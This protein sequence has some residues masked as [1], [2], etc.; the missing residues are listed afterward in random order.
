MVT[1]ER[2]FAQAYL[3]TEQL[4][5]GATATTISDP[6][7]PSVLGDPVTFVATV[8][9]KTAPGRAVPAGWVEFVVDGEKYGPP[10]KL[11]EHRRATL[12]VRRLEAGRHRVS[13]VYRPAQGSAFLPS[14]SPV[15]VHTVECAPTAGSDTRK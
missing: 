13:A 9:R 3:Q 12:E 10:M 1:G 15:E 6:Q 8:R 5:E 4:E 11:D 2:G 7:D 14:A